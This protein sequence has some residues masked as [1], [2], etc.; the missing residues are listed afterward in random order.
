[1]H[2]LWDKNLEKK[3]NLLNIYV[4]P[5]D[6][7]KES[8]LSELSSFCSKNKDPFIVGGDFNIMR[9]MSDKNKRFS[10]SRFSGILNIIIN[11][12]DL[13]KIHISGGDYTWSNNHL[14]P[15][16]KKLDMILMSREWEIMF[17]TVM[18]YKKPREMSDHN[19]LIIST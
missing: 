11:T 7:C 19:I 9:Y 6:D 2:L 3:W 17:P 8:F 10:P 12:N 1:M 5:H 14:N 18:V 4:S 15:T 13:R 16:L